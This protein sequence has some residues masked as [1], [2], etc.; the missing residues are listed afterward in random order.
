MDLINN[1]MKK[2]LTFRIKI[3][4]LLILWFCALRKT[5]RSTN[6]FFHISN[7]CPKK[8]SI[9]LLWALISII[10]IVLIIFMV[11]KKADNP[12]AIVRKFFEAIRTN[13]LQDASNYL[14]T[15]DFQLKEP[16]NALGNAI[17]SNIQIIKI[18]PIASSDNSGYTADVTL[19]V[20]DVRQIMSRATLQML[21]L[22]QEKTDQEELDADRDL[23][24]IYDAILEDGSLP[25]KQTICR[26]T[27]AKEHGRLKILP[28]E[29]LQKILDGEI[30]ENLKYIEMMM[31]NRV[32]DQNG[33]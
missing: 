24:A 11:Q 2:G 3:E 19:E 25:K 26:L 1:N 7:C 12:E 27:L 29:A 23:S 20:L 30:T 28:N 8:R 21:I 13:Q 17:R 9:R 16:A 14:M 4:N 22:R 31:N 10:G 32:T 18:E 6:K 5:I 15:D 33:N